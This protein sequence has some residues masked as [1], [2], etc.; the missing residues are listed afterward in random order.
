[1]TVGYSG[2]E[3]HLLSSGNRLIIKFDNRELFLR[4]GTSIANM[5]ALYANI[6]YSFLIAVEIGAGFNFTGTLATGACGGLVS[7]IR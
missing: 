5:D 2:S 6:D 4:T 3:T 1:M 7:R